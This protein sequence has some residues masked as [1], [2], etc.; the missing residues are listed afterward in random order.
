[1]KYMFNENYINVECMQ[2]S[3]SDM[4]EKLN[5][6]FLR[7]FTKDKINRFTSFLSSCGKMT[8][9][10]FIK[11]IKTIYNWFPKVNY[12]TTRFYIKKTLNDPNLL[13]KYEKS[14]FS[15][16]K[17]ITKNKLNDAILKPLSTMYAYISLVSPGN[18]NDT[19][20]DMMLKT[21]SDLSKD[22][23]LKEGLVFDD[24]L[25][26]TTLRHVFNTINRFFPRFFTFGTMIPLILCV[27]LFQVIF[28]VLIIGG[29][30][31]GGSVDTFTTSSLIGL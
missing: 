22:K 25:H 28:H 27:M 13:D 8:N 26:I 10:Y 16:L 2:E 15:Q 14:A 1:M 12:D 31:G 3:F 11:M 9:E 4:L 18:A 7:N 6:S 5:P 20:K 30:L 29:L 17:V 24:M 19:M 23:T 21:M